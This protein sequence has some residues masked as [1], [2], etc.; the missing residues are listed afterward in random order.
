MKLWL[1]S[2][3]FALLADAA[4]AAP[5]T[6][7]A[8]EHNGFTRLVIDLPEPTGF[9]LVGEKNIKIEI[10]SAGDGFDVSKAMI[11]L[12]AGRIRNIS[13]GASATELS[14]DLGCDCKVHARFEGA[15]L[16][17][18]VSGAAKLASLR[19]KMRPQ[20]MTRKLSVEDQGESQR[21]D[22]TL[23]LIVQAKPDEVGLPGPVDALS[24]ALDDFE[25]VEKLEQERS[26]TKQALLDQ[27]ARGMSQGLVTPRSTAVTSG[28]ADGVGIITGSVPRNDQPAGRNLTAFTSADRD[29][30]NR[31]HGSAQPEV[32]SRCAAEKSFDLTN[33]RGQES[34]EER[35]GGLRQSLFKEFDKI[36]AVQVHELAKAYIS[37]GFGAEALAVLDATQSGM[38]SENL[39]A[40]A[41]IVDGGK[42]S[43]LPASWRIDCDGPAA[44]WAFMGG[45]RADGILSLNERALVRTFGTLPV[46]LKSEFAPSLTQDLREIGSNDTAD[47]IV[48]LAQRGQRFKKE[49]LTVL[50]A[51]VEGEP[52]QVEQALREVVEGNNGGSAKALVNLLDV[53]LS[54]KLAI[55]PADIE[56]AFAYASELRREPIAA[57]LLR[58]AA[59]AMIETGAYE[60]GFEQ[61]FSLLDRLDSNKAR[62][63]L[64]RAFTVLSDEAGD[65]DY[66]KIA[67]KARRYAARANPESQHQIAKRAL[68]LGFADL[69][70]SYIVYASPNEAETERRLLRADAYL[71]EEHVDQALS[72]LVGLKGKEAN[73]LR[74]K[75]LQRGGE[76]QKA[77]V[78]LQSVGAVELAAEAA[79]LAGDI[80]AL[81]NMAVDGWQDATRLANLPTLE[82][83]GKPAL[84]GA[85]KLLEASS[86]LRAL[87]SKV[88]SN[89]LPNRYPA[90]N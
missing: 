8:G 12:G 50:A 6:V 81:E 43:V 66:L 74:A 86:E 18:D 9:R 21:R 14:V 53:Q 48:R 54:A 22:V 19:P 57:D 4:L 30:A 67:L 52:A 75:A 59:E 27:F 2:I 24:K 10:E 78:E 39:T 49:Q 17:V 71:L 29:F 16:V 20:S 60:E 72:E 58:V 84:Q 68:T 51:Q 23:P 89:E 65:V 34:F 42:V 25:S 7:R 87:T 70:I 90:T 73:R 55:A 79:W 69:A 37:F 11:R 85:E 13:Q 3:G 47:E 56:L 28:L 5:A 82:M 26:N 62:R 83:E 44:L 40:M 38:R 63:A 76:H 31:Q 33:W 77:V 35:V 61:L 32:S 88:L 46:Q 36:D 41:Q 15:M 1:F 45:Q 80:S 64:S